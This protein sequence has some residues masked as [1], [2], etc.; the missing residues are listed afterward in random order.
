MQLIYPFSGSILNTGTVTRTKPI[1]D[2]YDCVDTQ[3][4]D[5][6]TCLPQDAQLHYF[7]AG[8]K[9]TYRFN[10]TPDSLTVYNFD[11]TVIGNFNNWIYPNTIIVNVDDLPTGTN[12][13]YFSIMFRGDRRCFCFGYTRVDESGCG[14]GSILIKSTY[15]TRDC[16]GNIYN[17]DVTYSNER[18]FLAEVE[19]VGSIENAKLV[20][21]V[22]ISTKIYNQYKVNILQPLRQT[23]LLLEELVEVIMRGSNLTITIESGFPADV[24]I[25]EDYTEAITRTYDTL[26]EWYPSF[27][28]RTLECDLTSNCN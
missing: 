13:F 20:D 16:K 27:V 11:G 22:R 9:F 6:Y 21:D 7:I 12:C 5:C 10:F 28:V 25:C 3:F 2:L 26:R 14:I 19:Y 17:G 4:C 8:D 23:S 15:K 24:L 18:R 1:G